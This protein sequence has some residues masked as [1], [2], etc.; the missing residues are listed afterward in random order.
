LRDK[1]GAFCT[2]LSIYA[3]YALPDQVWHGI[4]NQL[5]DGS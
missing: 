4:I 3:P 5:K 2:R 1:Y